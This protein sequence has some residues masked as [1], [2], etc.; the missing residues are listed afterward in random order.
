VNNLFNKMPPV[1]NSYPG[2]VFGPYNSANYS[3]YGR[4]LYLEATYKFNTH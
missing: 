2:Y 1:D 4:Q 3:V